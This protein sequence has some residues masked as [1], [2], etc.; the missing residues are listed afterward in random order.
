MRG[1]SAMFDD[2][3]PYEVT[4]DHKFEEYL[5]TEHLEVIIFDDN[6]PVAGVPRSGV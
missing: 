1:G 4:Y 5:K 3:Q 2:V 6:A